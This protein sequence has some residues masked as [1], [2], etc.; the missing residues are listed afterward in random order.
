MIEIFLLRHAETSYNANNQFI[1]GRSN[2]LNLSE[3]GCKQAKEIGLQIG[4]KLGTFDI[5]QECVHIT[6]NPIIYSEEL[7]ELSQGDWEG[8]LRSKIY[9]SEMLAEINSNQWLFKAPNGE[10]QKE[11]E[12]RMLYF[13]EQNIINQYST[14]KF[15]IV[16]H[17]IA[18]K[19]LLR[20]I[21]GT[22][23]QMAYKLLMENASITKLRYDAEKGWYIDYINRICF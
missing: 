9:T 12:E 1:G 8:K 11:V 6:D 4:E 14:G 13:I 23:T 2:Y 3:N 18:F 5:I 19:C 7:Q 22:S 10:S 17:G 20:G 15:L 16:G 21:L